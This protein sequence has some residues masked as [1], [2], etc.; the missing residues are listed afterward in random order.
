[1]ERGRERENER[2]KEADTWSEESGWGLTE[3]GAK[4]QRKRVRERQQVWS[5]T[6]RYG[7]VWWGTIL[8]CTVRYGTVYRRPPWGGKSTLI[9][10][11]AS[12]PTSHPCGRGHLPLPHGPSGL[13]DVSNTY[14]FICFTIVFG[15]VGPLGS[16]GDFTDT[17]PLPRIRKNINS[18]RGFEFALASCA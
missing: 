4:R 5:C 16:V 3:K 8:Y 2:A 18:L 11:W 7:T 15:H 9:V 17:Y 6:V 13:C 10:F 1:M 12:S 14:P